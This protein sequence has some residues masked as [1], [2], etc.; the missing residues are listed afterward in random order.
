MVYASLMNKS[1]NKLACRSLP[2]LGG[3]VQARCQDP[4]TV[5]TKRRLQDLVLMVEGGDE[6]P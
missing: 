5:R 4:G 2:E 1:G 6:L 3:F